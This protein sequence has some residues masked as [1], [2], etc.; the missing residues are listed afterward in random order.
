M[1]VVASV[2]LLVNIAGVVI[3]RGTSEQSLNMKGA[4]FEVLSD[5]LTSVGVIIAA[6]GREHGH[7]PPHSWS[8]RGGGRDTRPTRL[9]AYF[10][11]ER[12]EC[13]HCGG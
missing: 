10:G 3:L 7:C 2:G 4:Y 9:V 6:L 12:N 8:N 13:S 11:S 1:L 5:L